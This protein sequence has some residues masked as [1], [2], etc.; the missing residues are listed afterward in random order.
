MA[1]TA[2]HQNKNPTVGNNVIIAGLS[3]QVATLFI[4]TLF[5]ADFAIRTM[6]RVRR[7]GIEGASDPIHMQLRGSH[8]FKWFLFSL[9]VA[10]LCIFTRCVFRVAELSKG[11]T[12][13]LMRTQKYFIGLEGAVVAAAALALNA[14]HPATCFKDG[15]DSPDLGSGGSFT[16]SSKGEESAN[17][18]LTGVDLGL[19]SKET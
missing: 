17:E 7:Q 3:V 1:S 9:S 5:A 2:T 19:Q 6:K 8:A 13:D 11:W 4:F 10:T 14:F 15:C 12:G 18:G 16:G